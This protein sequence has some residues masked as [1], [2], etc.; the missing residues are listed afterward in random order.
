M[1][2]FEEDINEVVLTPKILSSLQMAKVHK[3][4]VVKPR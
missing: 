1:D 2:L 3:D 4:H